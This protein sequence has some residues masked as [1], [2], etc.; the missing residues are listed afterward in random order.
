MKKNICFGIFLISIS[1]IYLLVEYHNRI[2]DIISGVLICFGILIILFK[3]FSPDKEKLF[4]ALIPSIFTVIGVII[5]NY[6]SNYNSEQYYQIKHLQELKE[7]S[8][9][10][11]MGLKLPFTQS[12]QGNLESKVLAEYYE[13]RYLIFSKDP[14]DL[15]EAKKQYDKGLDVIPQI[16]A[17]QK[18]LFQTLGKIRIAFVMDKDLDS[19]INS[20]YKYLGADIPILDKTKIKRIEDLENYHREANR[21]INVYVENEIKKKFEELFP[22]LLKQIK[23]QQRK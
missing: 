23:N 15:V 9:S 12:I 7:Q 10:T 14:S 13:T 16:S 3:D 2:F 19:K 18:E 1:L 5:G 11:I 17:N 22:L 20:L 8:Y 6:I 21:Q 4:L